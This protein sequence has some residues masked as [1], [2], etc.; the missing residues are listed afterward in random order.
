M[1]TPVADPA[2]D[3]A[4]D[5]VDLTSPSL[6]LSDEARAHTLRLARGALLFARDHVC[7]AVRELRLADVDTFHDDAEALRIELV[8]LIERLDM[9]GVQ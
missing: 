9:R 3:F 5:G 2:P 6:D 4:P 7:Y 8:S 1:P